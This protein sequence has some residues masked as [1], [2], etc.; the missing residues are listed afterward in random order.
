MMKTE[1]I[2]I[3]HGQANTGAQDEESYDRLSDIGHQQANWLGEYLRGHGEE[4]DRVICGSLRRHCETASGLDLPH[5]VA[6]DP[7]VNEMRYFDLAH[8]YHTQTQTPV[9][10]STEEF[11]QQIPH[12]LTAWQSGSLDNAHISYM[13]FAQQCADVMSEL[14]I[15]GGRSLIVTSGGV[16]GM[17]IA[18]HLALGPEGFAR[19]MLPIHNSSM[20]RFDVWN[21]ATHMAGYNATP[22]LDGADRRHA[23]TNI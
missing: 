18:Q 8:E 19:V 10:N 23:R 16:I 21:G 7:R 1:I 11:A 6:I 5:D 2:L 15:Q 3:R 13:D 4:F 20:H 22:H 9:P 12:L 14:A 17:A